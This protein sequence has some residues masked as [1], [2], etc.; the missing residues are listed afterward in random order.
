MNSWARRRKLVYVIAVTIILIGA[1][2]VPIF[3]TVYE[4]PTC[5]DGVKNGKEK[6]VDCGGAC[7]KLCSS[8]FLPPQVTWTRYEEIAPGIYNMAAYIVNPNTDAE[9][10]NVPYRMV[11][12]DKNGVP[13]AEIDGKVDI[14]PHRN[15]LAFQSSIDV[16]ESVP[17]SRTFEF[18]GIPEWT[19]KSDPLASIT[20]ERGKYEEGS[21]GSSY[22]VLLKNSNILPVSNVTVFVI[23]KD[24]EQNVI[25]FSKTI[26]EEIPAKGSAV[27]PFTWPLSRYGRVNSTEVLIVT[28]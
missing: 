19:K 1:V 7:E 13:V 17:V 18:T 22:M 25:G 16:N 24:V 27:A 26:I 10:R 21:A 8:S 28:E 6:D 11:M 3:F 2:G 14:P 23:L 5:F 4:A 20:Y 12:Y 15:T 9:A